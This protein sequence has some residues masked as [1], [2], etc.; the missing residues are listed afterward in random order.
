MQRISLNYLLG[1]KIS[2]F[3][4]FHGSDICIGA[5]NFLQQDQSS[6]DENT[7]E[8]VLSLTK[9]LSSE[10]EKILSKSAWAQAT[11]SLLSTVAGKIIL[12]LH[13]LTPLGADEAYRIAKLISRVTQLDDL[14]LPEIKAS[15]RF[16]SR[17]STPLTGRSY[18]T[19]AKF[20]R[21]T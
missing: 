15:N 17:R 10:R 7:V 14:F 2:Y 6:N 13:D 3:I 21:A 20:Y 4:A 12:D 18:I 11:G 5:Q 16:R 8:G 19:S 1:G 9:A